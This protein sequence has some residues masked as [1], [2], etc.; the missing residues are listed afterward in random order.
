MSS[1]ESRLLKECLPLIAERL[2]SHREI[3]SL[4][5]T[6]KETSSLSRTLLSVD[7][8]NV[9]EYINNSTQKHTK[10]GISRFADIGKI[11]FL[12]YIHLVKQGKK[13]MILTKKSKK[14]YR[15][16]FS[17][18]GF[19][20]LSSIITSSITSF[21]RKIHYII[22]LNCNCNTIFKRFVSKIQSSDAS[23]TLINNKT[24]QIPKN[25]IIDQIS[26]YKLFLTEDLSDDWC[27]VNF[28]IKT[29]D[30]VVEAY[31]EI[32]P[33]TNNTHVR[34]DNDR[35]DKQ[36][37]QGELVDFCYS[38]D[39]DINK[40]AKI[41]RDTQIDPVRNLVLLCECNDSTNEQLKDK[42]R[43][44][45][46]VVD[47]YRAR[48]IWKRNLNITFF[49]SSEV[50]ETI[51]RSLSIP[52]KNNTIKISKKRKRED[53]EFIPNKRVTFY[54]DDDIS[55]L[56]VELSDTTKQRISLFCEEEIDDEMS[57][58]GSDQISEEIG[59]YD[60]FSEDFRL[61]D[62]NFDNIV[63]LNNNIL[64][65][66]SNMLFVSEFDFVDLGIFE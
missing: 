16:M 50:S 29:C 26:D 63:N 21:D 28:T 66:N 25:S 12:H 15:D 61:F 32:G 54:K 43:K 3:R 51:A 4:C 22:E 2:F 7:Q 6:S 56:N 1:L 18:A 13:V 11:V 24:R 59:E 27:D 58:C 55:D 53:E 42:C 9:L 45:R 31:K 8:R 49:C 23:F 60:I 48:T 34:Y 41:E 10:A 57:V 64:D 62:E 36:L 14:Y 46:D 52:D 5:I 65:H 40:I 47:L 37:F 35:K 44:L 19:V 33:F 39:V 30:N 38:K 17:K 20:R